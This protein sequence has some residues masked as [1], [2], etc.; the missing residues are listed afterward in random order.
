MALDEVAICNLALAAIRVAQIEALTD[1]TNQAQACN[2]SY[3]VARDAALS[4]FD[5]NFAEKEATLAVAS[6]ETASGWT[7]VYAVPSDYIRALRIF[8]A[9]GSATKIE[10]EIRSNAAR[11]A[12]RIL[13]NHSGAILI[14]TARIENE[15]MFSPQFVDAL[16]ARLA[17][18]LSPLRADPQLK[19][20]LQQAYSLLISQART[21]NANE[22]EKMP[23]NDDLFINAR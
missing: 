20:S 3:P 8:N 12:Q 11:N 1:Q 22:G 9:A 10:F 7:Y 2:R 17:L 18:D 14:Y 4:D 13:S 23:E 21:S 15:N 16:V 5:W 6:G 19:L